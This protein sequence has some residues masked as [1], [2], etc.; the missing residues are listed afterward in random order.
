M[1]ITIYNPSGKDT[2]IPMPL[3][4]LKSTAFWKLLNL[5][6]DFD[7]DANKQA[8]AQAID[9]LDKYK[10]INGS[11]TFIDVKDKNGEGMKI[12]I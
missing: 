3:S 8:I 12:V 7:I 10:K 4:M 5:D 2:N 6:K 9:I 11:F 1:K